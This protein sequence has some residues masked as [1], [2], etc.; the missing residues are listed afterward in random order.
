MNVNTLTIDVLSANQA[1]PVH[2]GEAPVAN[3]STASKANRK[4]ESQSHNNNV[5]ANTNEKG[6][7]ENILKL[8]LKQDAASIENGDISVKTKK[9]D[10]KA[11]AEQVN[12]L[13]GVQGAEQNQSIVGGKAISAKKTQSVASTTTIDNDSK[14]SAQPIVN[15]GLTSAS[16]KAVIKE[17]QGTLDAK[18]GSQLTGNQQKQ[19][20]ELPEVSSN[21]NS[22][23]TQGKS[24]KE[25]AKLTDTD[26][27]K[28]AQANNAGSVKPMEL[29]NQQHRG[30]NN[31]SF[32]LTNQTLPVQSKAQIAT[33][34]AATLNGGSDSKQVVASMVSGGRTGTVESTSSDRIKDK[35]ISD[36]QKNT[37]QSTDGSTAGKAN[38]KLNIEKVELSSVQNNA[39]NSSSGN[40]IGQIAG[41]ISAGQVGSVNSSVITV[42]PSAASGASTTAANTSVPDTATV[43]R[44]QIYDSIQSSIQ[45]GQK[46]ITIHLNP[47]EL[48][49]VSMKF[50]EQGNGLI[51][52]LEASNPQTRAEIQQAIPELIRSLEQSGISVKQIDVALSD[53]SGRHG[54]ESFK[55]NSSQ[56]QWEQFN[57]HSFQDTS[58]NQPARDSFITP[59]YHNDTADVH[60]DSSLGTHQSTPSDKLLDVLI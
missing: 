13:A 57:N 5:V 26:T 27:K 6:T 9:S 2:A 1:Q 29:P 51:G 50:S 48:G 34:T 30:I 12:P 11:K 19:I 31:E 55:D 42:Q 38:E 45:Q 33:S 21:V 56:A 7:F 58:W 41:G 53:T 4:D 39:A 10:T 43:I 8:R 60:L 44:E 35:F 52:S 23:Q 25:T 59:T 47:P 49:R 20:T 36:K 3:K 17:N 18:Q 24:T 22:G 15:K 16:G 46:Q 40:G 37:R 32:G 28:N 54:Q 14:E